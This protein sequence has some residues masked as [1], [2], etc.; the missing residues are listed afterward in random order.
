MDNETEI[1][2]GQPPE[3]PESFLKTINE[4]QERPIQTQVSAWNGQD[5]ALN[6]NG[7]QIIPDSKEKLINLA[8]MGFQSSKKNEEMNKQMASYNQRI[9]QLSEYEKLD[10]MLN[11]NQKMKSDF[12]NWWNQY[13]QSEQQGQAIANDP[14]I[15]G[16]LEQQKQ[17]ESYF[18]DQQ[19]SKE[20][21]SLQSKYSN[22]NWNTDN[23]YGNLMQQLIKF[24]SE[25][26]Y[27]NLEHGF[28]IM[29]FDNIQSTSA[30][31][32]LKKQQEDF[33]TRNR[34]GI[35]EGGNSA[36]EQKIAIPSGL[37][38]NLLT[39]MAKKELM[40]GID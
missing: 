2:P 38:Y 23:G 3:T 25:N 11:S 37:N 10:E 18:A 24:C 15:D 33:K 6:F 29:M 7:Q 40:A 32:A 21:D 14:R 8:Q 19:L 20:M 5:F 27:S 26:Q 4:N 13:G 12:L 9:N 1:I 36:T 31:E 35:V 22:Q 17:M 28:K 16:L 34:A 30:Q 39:A